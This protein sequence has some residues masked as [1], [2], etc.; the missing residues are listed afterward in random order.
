MNPD[1]LGE[2]EVVGGHGWYHSKE[3]W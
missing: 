2:D 3:H 1:D